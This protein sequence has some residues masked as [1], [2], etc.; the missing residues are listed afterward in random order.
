MTKSLTLKRAFLPIVAASMALSFP[1]MADEDDHEHTPLEKAMKISSNALKSLRKMDKSDW[2]GGAKAARTAA[3]GC[4]QGMEFIPALVKEM[5][6]GK[7]KDK[8]IADYR[9]MMGLSYAAF[10]E[11]EIG[12]LEESQEKVDAAMKKLKAGK[13]EGHK[14]YTDD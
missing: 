4:R 10:C 5:A 13:K 14:K 2:A 9:R 12:Y 7:E 11:L 1:A 3:D 8:A 6:D